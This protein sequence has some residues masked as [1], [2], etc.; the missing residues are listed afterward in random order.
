MNNRWWIIQVTGCL[1][2]TVALAYMRMVGLSA[3]SY[4][5]YVILQVAFIGWAFPISY[6]KAPSFLQ[7]WF[8]GNATLALGGFVISC[9]YL[10]EIANIH[11]YIGAAAVII[12][13]VLLIL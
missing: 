6:A 4:A 3:S 2:I 7:A 1:S 10:K 11:N 9:F 13:S 12:G 5:A 8:L